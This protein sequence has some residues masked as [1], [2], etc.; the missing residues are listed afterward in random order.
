MRGVKSNI[1]PIV[2]H[3]RS[4][5]EVQLLCRI[6]FRHTGKKTMLNLGRLPGNRSLLEYGKHT[7]NGIGQ[8]APNGSFHDSAFDARGNQLARGKRRPRIEPLV[9]AKDRPICRSS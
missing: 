2:G 5:E 9:I 6:A 8:E 1:W 3:C 4:M 7:T